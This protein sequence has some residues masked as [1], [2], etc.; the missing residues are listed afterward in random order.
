M[1]PLSFQDNL[2][3]EFLQALS[4]VIPEARFYLDYSKLFPIQDDLDIFNQAGI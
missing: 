1:V 2:G 4:S 3:E